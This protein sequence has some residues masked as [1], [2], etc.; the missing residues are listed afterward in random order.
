MAT[1]L[2]Y[3]TFWQDVLNHCRSSNVK[4]TL[5]DCFSILFLQQLLNPLL[6]QSSDTIAGS[7]LAVL[8]Y[9]TVTVILALWVGKFEFYYPEDASEKSGVMR[10]VFAVARQPCIQK[11]LLVTQR[12][13]L[14][15]SICGELVSI[16]SS[17]S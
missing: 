17:N 10:T 5:L 3:L 2:S 11:V 9:M 16:W 13:Q 15:N 12:A 1:F 4:Q 6:L 8:H 14:A 7:S